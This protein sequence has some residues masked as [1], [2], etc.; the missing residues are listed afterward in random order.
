MKTLEVTRI[1]KVRLSGEICGNTGD[2]RLRNRKTNVMAELS[3]TIRKNLN[4]YI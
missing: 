2:I 4:K 1:I 3:D